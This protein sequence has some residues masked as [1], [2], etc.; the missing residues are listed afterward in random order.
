MDLILQFFAERT[1]F[2]FVVFVCLQTSLLMVLALA[3]AHLLRHR[4]AAAEWVLRATLFALLCAPLVTAGW[5]CSEAKL[6]DI[7]VTFV[8]TPLTDGPEP[9]TQSFYATEE[10]IRPL[11]PDEV[12]LGALPGDGKDVPTEKGPI[13]TQQQSD[14]EQHSS[15]PAGAVQASTFVPEPMSLVGLLL[16]LWACGV[17]WG[18]WR[19]FCSWVAVRRLIHC[20][21]PTECQRLKS[22]FDLCSGMLGTDQRVRVQVSE[23]VDSPLVAG[24]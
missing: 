24:T 8:T 3:F 4:A 16:V 6:I 5:W 7:K 20:S 14:A 22:A 17:V 9:T 10:G 13:V 2:T 21:Q 23:R 19:T 15:V 11:P 1:L 18:C 12:I